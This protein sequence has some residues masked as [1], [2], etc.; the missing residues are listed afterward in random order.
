MAAELERNFRLEIANVLFMDIVGYSKLLTNQQCELLEK[1]NQIVRESTEFRRAEA[2]GELIRLPTGDGMALIFSR[3]AEAPVECALEIS[4][5]LKSHSQL[6]IRMGIHSGP[7]NQVTD[8]NDRSNVAG[9]GINIAQRVMDCGD[10]GHILLSKRVADDLAQYAQWANC[11]HELGEVEVKHGVKVALVNLYTAEVGNPAQPDKVK[12]LSAPPIP[13]A[14]GKSIAVLPFVDLSQAKD[15]EY[16]CDGISEEILSALA[17]VEGLRVAAR[18]SS[19]S[20]KGKNVEVG[21]VARQLR[22]ENILEGSLRRDG[23]RIRITAQLID[24]RDGFQRWSETYEREL[25]GI[26][27]IQDEITGAIVNALKIKLAAALPVQTQRNTQSYELYLKGRFHWNKRTSEALKK[28]IEYFRQAIEKDPDYAFAYTG[29]ADCYSSLGLSLDAG[30]LSPRAAIPKAKAAAKKAS[31]I[32]DNLAETHTS[33]AFI[34]L[35]YDWDWSGAETEFKR[36][37][38]LNPNYDNAHHWYSHYLLAL[39]RTEE[40][41]VESKRALELDRVGLVINLHL[42]WHYL[43]ARQYDLAINQFHKTLEMDRRYGQVHWYLGQAYGRKGM[44]REALA[45]LNKATDMLKGNVGVK[46]E[47]GYV[48]AVAGKQAAAKKVI[49]ELEQVSHRKYVSSYHFAL[50]HTGLGERDRAF[51]SLENACKERSDSLVYL[52]I[53]PRFDDLRADPRF[54]R[55]LQRIGLDSSQQ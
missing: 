32:D 34:K 50:I 2:A 26:F 43:F 8:V 49:K 54:A 18:T 37:I 29:L 33:L 27:A 24:G 7:V 45:E 11:L 51:E 28:A 35:N 39:G 17:K 22:V 15:Q 23:N 48:N 52:K 21:E 31:E 13:T 38:Q 40:S 36:A 20:F 1:L 41:L 12:Q 44:Y 9:A 10:A 53:D 55:V 42:G 14:Q 46:A 3:S 19:F 30:A 5:A 4:R 25:Q 6:R 16:F 47:I